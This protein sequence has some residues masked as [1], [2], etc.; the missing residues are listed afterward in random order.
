MQMYCAIY[1]KQFTRREAFCLALRSIGS[2]LHH[3]A[4]AFYFCMLLSGSIIADRPSVDTTLILC[5]QHWIVLI[6]QIFTGM[7]QKRL[8]GL[9]QLGLEIWF[10]WIVFSNLEHMHWTA[11][12]AGLEMIVAHLIWFLS[13]LVPA[14]LPIHRRRGGLVTPE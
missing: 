11:Q 12:V 1:S 5:I 4:A 9:I 3:S 14:V 10:E 13:G 8:Y 6:P 2:L 7:W